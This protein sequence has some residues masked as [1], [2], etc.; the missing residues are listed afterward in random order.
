MQEVLNHGSFIIGPEVNELEQML[1]DY[2]GSKYCVSVANGTDALQ[3]ALMAIDFKPGQEVITPG[4]SYIASAEA[5]KILGLTPVYVDVDYNSCNI[6][7]RKIQEKISNKTC[8]IIAV[9]LY[10]QCANFE[11]IKP[12]AHKASIPII[13]DAAQSFGAKH[14][15]ALSCTLGD[16][17]CTSFFPTKPLGCYGDGGAIFTDNEKYYSQVKSLSRHGQSK[18]YIHDLVGINS[19]LDTLQAA[20]LLSKLEIFSEEIEKR[21]EIFQK[22]CER[23]ETVEEIILPSILDINTS[24]FAQFTLK[25]TKRDNLIESL[26]NADIPYAIHYPMPIYMQK[27]YQ[28]NISLET[29]EEL[30]KTVISLPFN[31]YLTD[32]EI[33]L[34]C[35]IIKNHYATS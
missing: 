31:P 17:S 20:I 26:K 32:E 9:N 14:H 11:E 23:L 24:V 1:S 21:Q 34:I 13:E 3:L 35:K 22:Y 16:I 29:T 6:D 33:D 7:P 12:I 18:R 30:C 10:G 19:R 25:V 2:T 5:V 28:T 27:A 4:F 15:G 8:A